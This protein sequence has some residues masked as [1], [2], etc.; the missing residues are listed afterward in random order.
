M[1]TE[2]DEGMTFINRYE[3]EYNIVPVPIGYNPIDQLTKNSKREG[4]N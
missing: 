3:E 4:H 1:Q 2:I